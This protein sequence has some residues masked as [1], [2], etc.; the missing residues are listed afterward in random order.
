MLEV[1][2]ILSMIG[3]LTNLALFCSGEDHNTGGVFIMIIMFGV[4]MFCS[5]H[6]M[7]NTHKVVMKNINTNTNIGYFQTKQ[8]C[9][10][11]KNNENL[12][13]LQR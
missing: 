1:I 8:E 12:I 5:F 3:L 6:D 7:G 11:T 10:K 13:C 2:F 9:E 4:I